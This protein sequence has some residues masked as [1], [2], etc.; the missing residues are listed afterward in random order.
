MPGQARSLGGQRRGA[1]RRPQR[2]KRPHV[3]RQV[4]PGAADPEPRSRWWCNESRS[5]A[6][7]TGCD[8]TLRA[9][10]GAWTSAGRPSW[11]TFSGTPSMA[12]GRI[13]SSTR[14]ARRSVDER[15]NWCSKIEKSRTTRCFRW[16]GS[17]VRRR[18]FQVVTRAATRLHV[19]VSTFIHSLSLT[20]HTYATSRFVRTLPTSLASRLICTVKTPPARGI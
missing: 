11:R 12:P 6:K 9:R 19:G 2:P 20:R 10:S 8:S 17:R 1:P 4:H 3:H 13:T 7:M 14:D 18:G 15:V 16:L 5:C